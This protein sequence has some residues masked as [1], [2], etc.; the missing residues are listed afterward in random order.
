MIFKA[1]ISEPNLRD[2]SIIYTFSQSYMEILC[3]LRFLITPR[4]ESKKQKKNKTNEKLNI[5]TIFCST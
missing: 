2:S 1:R 5:F 4:I 3:N